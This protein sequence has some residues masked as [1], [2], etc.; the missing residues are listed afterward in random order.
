MKSPS[1]IKCL[2]LLIV[3]LLGAFSAGCNW[4]DQE[5]VK[6]QF[7]ERNPN[8]SII[9]FS[10]IEGD[11]SA[12]YYEFRFRRPDSDKVHTENWTFLYRKE[13]DSWEVVAVEPIFE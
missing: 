4:P 3:L 5:F 13:S 10:V 2:T 12:V 6:K 7:L 8:C 1:I 11:S 9:R